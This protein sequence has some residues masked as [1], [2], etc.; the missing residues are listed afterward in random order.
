MMRRD[1]RSV[2]AKPTREQR[3][4]VNRALFGRS[5]VILGVLTFA[6][7]MWR[8][9]YSGSCRTDADCTGTDHAC[10]FRVSDGCGG[11]GHCAA[12]SDAC[13]ELAL[14]IPGCGCNG[15]RAY[16]GCVS[17]GGY[18]IPVVSQL[19]CST[20]SP[21]PDAGADAPS[22]IEDSAVPLDASSDAAD[23]D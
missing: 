22:F 16:P 3:P 5:R 23:A 11:D 8:C 9:N 19:P 1:V 20:A 7:M 6:V 14:K 17:G 15:S 18:D 2:A 10:V 4:V 21:S 13:D 12:A